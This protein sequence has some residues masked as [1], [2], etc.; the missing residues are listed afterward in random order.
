MFKTNKCVCCFVAGIILVSIGVL[1]D[2][3]GIGASLDIGS[4][5]LAVIVVGIIFIIC[6]LR[7]CKL[8][9]CCCG[10]DKKQ[11]EQGT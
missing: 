2:H 10:N 6:G 4:K 7:A 8:G 5:Q 3:I 1:A 11:E 9:K